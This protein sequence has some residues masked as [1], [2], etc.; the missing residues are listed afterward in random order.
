MLASAAITLFRN[1][2]GATLAATPDATVLGWLA[3]AISEYSKHRPIHTS[4]TVTAVDNTRRYASPVAR[5]RFIEA[6]FDTTD[7]ASDGVYDVPFEQEEADG[8]VVLFLAGTIPDGRTLTV[9]VSQNHARPTAVGDTLTVADDEV[10]WPLL[11]VKAAYAEGKALQ[12]AGDGRWKIENREEDPAS[13]GK[14]AL[15]LAEAF[16]TRFKNE[17]TK[18]FV[19]YGSGAPLLQGVD[20]RDSL[21]GAGRWQGHYGWDGSM[22][23]SRR[24]GV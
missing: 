20:R 18:P 7:T 22:P 12:T 2:T 17:M 15:A 5:T 10:Q 1:D 8:E 23:G 21:T 24:R 11:L 4:G 6:V 16:R 3:D 14:T 19:G 9:Y 13:G